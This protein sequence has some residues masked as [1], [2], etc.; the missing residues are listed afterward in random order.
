M[1]ELANGKYVSQ[2][3]AIRQWWPAAREVLIGVAADYGA[4]IVEDDLGHRI[5]QRTGITTRQP[6]PEW[7][8]N[9]LGR[10]AADAHERGEPRLTSL[11][12][13]AERR[14][15]DDNPSVPAGSDAR[16]REQVA[17]EDRLE[18]YRYYGATMPADGGEPTVLSFMPARPERAARSRAASP[19]A[20][21]SRST[22]AAPPAPALRE[23]TCPSC[24]MVVPVAATCRDCGEPLP[25]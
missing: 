9:V 12:V 19:S 24:F 1:P 4:F 17:A 16:T 13:T 8:N 3:D 20:A 7:I 22:K 21:R 10:V 14:I 11:C 25:A 23:T 6:T 5:Q 18:C 2:S 15:A